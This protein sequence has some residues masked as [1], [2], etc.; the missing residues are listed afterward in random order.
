M[1]GALW[2]LGGNAG[3]TSFF[4]TAT[5]G[6]RNGGRKGNMGGIKETEKGDKEEADGSP[7]EGRKMEDEEVLEVEDEGES[8]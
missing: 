8:G 3:G 7:G 5:L 6:S 2:K 1:S 4:A